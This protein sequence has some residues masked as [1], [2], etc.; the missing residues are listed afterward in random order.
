MEDALPLQE[1]LPGSFRMLD[2]QRYISFLWGAFDSNYQNGQYQMALLPYHMLYMSFVYFS[3][4]QVRLIRPTDFFHASIFQRYE[5]KVTG[6]TSPFKFHKI[7][8][9]EVFKYLRIIGCDEEQTKPFA[10]LVIE[11]NSLAH[12]NGNITCADQVAAD[13]RIAEILKQVRAIQMHMTPTLHLC[14]KGFLLES[15]VPVDEREYE[16]STDQIRELL[17]HK[18]YFSN[19]DI[20]ACRSFDLET[21]REEPQFEQIKVLFEDFVALYPPELTA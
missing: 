19:K 4:W 20:E 9:T 8:E 14:L 21:M 6:I 5:K 17:V 1:Y 15:A 12:A 16:D 11:R 2:E 7:T 3:I 18:Y 10:N 13:E